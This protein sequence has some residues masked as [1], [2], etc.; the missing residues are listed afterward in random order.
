MVLLAQD[1][2]A[3]VRK[4]LKDGTYVFKD[5][6]TIG[7]NNVYNELHMIGIACAVA[8][9]PP[10]HRC[11]VLFFYLPT[12]LTRPVAM[13]CA[14]YKEARALALPTPVQRFSLRTLFCLDL[15]RARG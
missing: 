5:N 13:R 9:S 3:V 11:F 4:R 6:E 15:R 2:G 8:T 1:V 12:P 7:D 10:T 14:D